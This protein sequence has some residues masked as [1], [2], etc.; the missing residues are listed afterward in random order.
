[1]SEDRL[2]LL[3]TAVAEIDHLLI[4]PHNDPDPDAVA[5][6]LA[7]RYLMAEK[8]NIDVTIAYH[9][10][11]GRAENKALVDYLGYPLQPLAALDETQRLPVAL[12][13]TQPEAGNNALPPGTPVTVV[14][15]HHPRQPATTS[16]KFADTRT[17]VGATSTILTEY[18]QAA[19]LEPDQQLATALFY[20]IK[21]DTMG[22][23]REASPAD[24][25]AYFYLHPR[26]NFD[27]LITIE[28]AQVPADYFKSFDSALHAARIYDGVVFT[29]VGLMAYPDLAAETADL[30]LRLQGS[31]WIICVGVFED[32]LILSVRT[33]SRTGGAGKLAQAIV[34]N[35]GIAGGHGSMAGGHIP[36]NGRESKRV[37]ARIRQRALQY[38]NVAPEVKGQLLI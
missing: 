4:L 31:Q 3:L 27:A 12:I 8:A 21:T 13:D 20:G 36:L 18:L 29:C 24:T 5:S 17:D 11:I 10:L 7:F 2:K 38:L 28:R 34:G 14:I 15:D 9:G 6:A 30:L 19:G 35:R 37:A 1:M 33:R 23:S 26:V 25:A 16:A 32:K 22:L